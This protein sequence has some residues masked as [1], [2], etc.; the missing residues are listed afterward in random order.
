MKKIKEIIKQIVTIL[1]YF[2]KEIFL[3]PICLCSSVVNNYFG[4]YH[5]NWG[6]D[7]N[8][9]F[10]K[11]LFGRHI[12]FYNSTPINKL[13]FK[14]N[15]AIIGSIITFDIINKNTIIWGAG[16]IDDK[17][18][19]KAIPQKILAVRGPLTRDYLLKKGIECPKIYGDP[20]LLLPQFIKNTNKKKKYKMG[21]I[22]HKSDLKSPKIQH[23]LKNKNIVLFTL[24]NYKNW[25]DILYKLF[26]C[27]YIVS[28]SLHGLIISEAYK[29]PNTWIEI[30][31][32]LE[33]NHFKFHDF[34]LSI[35]KD[36]K[37]PILINEYTTFEDLYKLKD[38]WVPGEINIEKLLSVCP[39]KIK[40]KKN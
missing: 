25:E 9:Y 23:L 3:R 27:E 10:L 39:F 20:A 4:I 30:D 6:D 33:G 34:F 22:P 40:L 36:R 31:G 16:V 1:L 8:Y 28:S 35:K 32:Q 7:I 17:E 29:I 11:T 5:K 24:N 18:D 37:E 12:T 2:F 15:Y 26:E 21:I 14:K 38:L 13:L 19:I